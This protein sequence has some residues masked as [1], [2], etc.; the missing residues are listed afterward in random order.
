[1]STSPE[2]R[3]LAEGRDLCPPWPVLITGANGFIAGHLALRLL[4]KGC[5]VA[6]ARR[7]EAAL[8]SP[9]KEDIV[10]ADS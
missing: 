4:S 1:M 10:Q 7:P 6:A 2:N 5:Q 8:C 3:G 9:G